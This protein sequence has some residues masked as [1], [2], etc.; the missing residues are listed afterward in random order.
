MT[1]TAERVAVEPIPMTRPK[2]PVFVPEPAP[3]K[4]NPLLSTF[5]SLLPV[6]TAITAIIAVR[7]FL[8]FA[9]VGAFILAQNALADTTYHGMWVLVAYCA[10]TILPLVWMDIY[11]KRKS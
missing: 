6:F 3:E 1:A 2:P 8:L 10:F 4:P 9:I 5:N 7:L 11:G